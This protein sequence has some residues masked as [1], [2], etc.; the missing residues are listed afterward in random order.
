MFLTQTPISLAAGVMIGR[1][2][3]ND[4]THS[5]INLYI[6]A[7]I[8][9]RNT[10]KGQGGS[11]SK[12]YSLFGG[13]VI[14]SLTC[15]GKVGRNLSRMLP[16]KIKSEGDFKMW[17]IYF[18]AH[19]F[20][21]QFK[22]FLWIYSIF[23]YDQSTRNISSLSPNNIVFSFLSIFHSVSLRKFD[24]QWFLLS[25]DISYSTLAYR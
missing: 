5:A 3:D 17:S 11:R 14:P 20:P 18:T 19:Q 16:L 9:G 15:K 10:V 24:I 25:S 2:K 21:C 23:P 22:E 6:K 12:S 13:M 7:V 8:T 1:F 4:I